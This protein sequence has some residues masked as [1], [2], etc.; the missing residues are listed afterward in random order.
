MNLFKDRKIN[1]KYVFIILVLIVVVGSVIIWSTQQQETLSFLTT[2]REWLERFLGR[3]YFCSSNNDCILK[4]A[5]LG[6]CSNE[7]V[8]GP[9]CYHT[10][11]EPLNK[12]LLAGEFQ[13]QATD[14]CS[15]VTV[16]R[17]C[18]C[19]KNRCVVESLP[20]ENQ[21][22]K[23]L[24]SNALMRE[25][26]LIPGVS[27]ESYLVIYI[28]DP[29]FDDLKDYETNYYMTCPESTMGQAIEGVYH[30]GLFQSNSLVDDQVIYSNYWY[31]DP[32]THFLG[33]GPENRGKLSFRNTKQNI[34]W[35]FNGPEPSEEEK[36]ELEIVKLIRLED[37]TGDGLGYEFKLTGTTSPCGHSE[38][39]IAG[40]DK[41]R[42]QAVVYPIITDIPDNV[43]YPIITDFKISYWGDNFL[44]DS[45]G[46]VEWYW[47]CGDHGATEESY[48]SYLFNS[49]NQSYV[50]LKNET[51][52]CPNH[53][54]SDWPTYEND[55]LGFQLKYPPGYTFSSLGPNLAQQEVEKGKQISGTVQPSLDTIAFL[56]ENGQKQF[57]IEIFDPTEKTLSKKGYEEDYLYTCGPCDLRWGFEPEGIVVK[58]NV[59]A[60]LDVL[61][62][63]GKVLENYRACDYF[64]N[65]EN[66]LIVVSTEILEKYS[67]FARANSTIADTLYTLRILD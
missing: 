6:C 1:W 12:E 52:F 4:E 51:R 9:A 53:L 22:Q 28:E 2:S 62:V 26:E 34:H 5:F 35:R 48:Q 65:S 45:L 30:L 42:N 29:K 61:H 38:Y 13:C 39:L 47:R 55:D 20:V 66:N 33:K 60:A 36:N 49:A 21:V 18:L 10:A 46:K 37:L 41:K 43:V 58:R 63:E 17:N 15:E 59:E 57:Q 64:K 7:P 23:L 11:E 50:C 16:A 54:T 32:T 31:V 25:V 19:R 8:F 56:N 14:L 24:P 67:D 40:Y 27:P 44:P 3:G